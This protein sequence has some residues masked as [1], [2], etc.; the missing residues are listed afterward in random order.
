MA[1]ALITKLSNIRRIVVRPTS[2]II[3]YFEG[4]QNAVA[5]GNELNVDFVLD[6]RVQ[7]MSGACG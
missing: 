5:A 4:E 7:R 2:S 6:G 3:K 1:D